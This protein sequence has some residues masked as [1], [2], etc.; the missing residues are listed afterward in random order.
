MKY[1]EKKTYTYVHTHTHTHTH[2][3]TVER[4]FYGLST[5]LKTALSHSS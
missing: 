3:R 4:Y 5:N 1:I 2:L